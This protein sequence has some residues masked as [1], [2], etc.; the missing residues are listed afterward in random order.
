MTEA[1]EKW[2]DEKTHISPSEEYE[3][4]RICVHFWLRAFV[5][6]VEKRVK[7]ADWGSRCDGLED[8]WDSLIREFGLDKQDGDK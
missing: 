3:G 8:Q 6:E 2:V 5:K 1:F 4:S 7:E